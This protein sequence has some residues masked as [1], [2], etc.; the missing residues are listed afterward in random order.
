MFPQ[1]LVLPG[2][3]LRR[4]E[5]VPQVGVLGHDPERL[6]LAAAAD[7]DREV[8]LHRRRRN[9]QSVEG[10]VAARRACDLAAVEQGPDRAHGL[11]EPVQPLAEP[12][13]E[14]DPERCVLELEPRAADA[15][16]R[17]PAADVVDRD[18]RLHGQARVAERVR[19]DEQPEGDSLGGLGQRSESGVALVDR[20]VRVAED[21]V[22]V[23][24]GPQVVVAERLGAA[25]GLKERRPVAGLAPE[26]DPDLDLSHLLPL[27]S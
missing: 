24:P 26:V 17:P 11:V 27:R 20:L 10:V 2:D 21:R 8:V 15:E 9:P 16:D 6:L 12:V 4:A 7:H 1:D 25:A 13:A 23:V 18:R 5:D 22:D 14:V 19:P 3:G